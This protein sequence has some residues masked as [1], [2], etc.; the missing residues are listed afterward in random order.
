MNT[1]GNIQDFEDLWMR[2]TY[3]FK[4]GGWLVCVSGLLILVPIILV[5]LAVVKHTKKEDLEER[6]PTCVSKEDPLPPTS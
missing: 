3:G 5:I 6:E 4:Q 1:V 2:L